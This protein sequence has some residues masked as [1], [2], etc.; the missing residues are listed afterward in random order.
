MRQK[1]LFY[2][3]GVSF[4]I[5]LIIF[6]MLVIG[7]SIFFL[8]ENQRKTKKNSHRKATELCDYGLQKVM[9]DALGKINSDTAKLNS[10]PKT[11][12][13]D[14]WYK[15]NVTI[16]KK[17]TIMTLIIESEG[18]VKSQSVVQKKEVCLYQTMIDSNIVWVPQ[19]MKR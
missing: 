7:F 14:G 4:R 17:D 10:I 8:I 11:L 12:F 19:H 13:R 2:N 6:S 18:C 15:V 16:S 5:T 1:T 3:G 9:A